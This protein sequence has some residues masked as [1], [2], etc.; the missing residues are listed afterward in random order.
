MLQED[1]KVNPRHAICHRHN[2]STSKAVTRII[3]PINKAGM[4]ST[5]DTMK[6][7]EGRGTE[8]TER[9]H[10][11]GSFLT[12]TRTSG[13]GTD[14]LYGSLLRG[15]RQML[16]GSQKI[17]LLFV[18][19]ATF[20][21]LSSPASQSYADDHKGSKHELVGDYKHR[22]LK[23]EQG[24]NG[25]H[26]NETTGEMAAWLF[27][28]ANFPAAL[29]IILKTFAKFLPPALNVKDPL[30]RFNRRQK[31]YLMKLHYWL[32]PI[33]LGIALTHFLLSS[34]KSTAMP[35]WGL[36][37]M[38]ATV[39]FGL[40][41]KFKLSPASMRQGVY[42]FHTSPALLIAAISILLIGHTIAD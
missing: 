2:L 15:K 33:A 6:N 36:M 20:G 26:G 27:G 10:S 25:D 19:F 32:N 41:M 40:M 24:K 4:K 1:I 39:L 13:T 18:I 34:C 12:L 30:T 7:T 3:V 28:I 23:H 5:V 38:F 8:S 21:F 22:L 31:K 14:D 29:S 37:I 11:S 17:L 16:H 35:E 42:R 9:N